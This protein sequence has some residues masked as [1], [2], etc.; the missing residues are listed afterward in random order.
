MSP[1][2]GSVFPLG[3]GG[4]P[5]TYIIGLLRKYMQSLLKILNIVLDMCYAFHYCK[6]ISSHYYW[7]NCT[8]LLLVLLSFLSPEYFSVNNIYATLVKDYCV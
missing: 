1:L 6:H 3:K 5:R 2:P 7:N 4:Y 8:K